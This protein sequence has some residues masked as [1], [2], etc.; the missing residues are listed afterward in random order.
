MG[1]RFFDW[2]ADRRTAFSWGEA[3]C[4]VVHKCDV[5]FP[6]KYQRTK[7]RTH[8]ENIADLMNDQEYLRFTPSVSFSWIMMTVCGEFRHTIP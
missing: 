4:D 8:F 6:T 3:A 7:Q 1:R 5:F 2:I